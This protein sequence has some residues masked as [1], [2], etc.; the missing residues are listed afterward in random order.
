MRSTKPALAAALAAAALLAP[1]AGH[2]GHLVSAA[3]TV[4]SP[5]GGGECSPQPS[6]ISVVGDY[7]TPDAGAVCWLLDGTAGSASV[8]IDDMLGTPVDAT[9]ELLTWPDDGAPAHTDT[10]VASGD[11]CGST[12]IPVGAGARELLISLGGTAVQTPSGQAS[13]GSAAPC[14]SPVHG[15]VT[16]LLP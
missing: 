11:F 15:T 16:A 12:S 13:I 2:A 3:Y 7:S 6:Y 10:I 4:A 1:H 5:T 8:E 14:P 9:W